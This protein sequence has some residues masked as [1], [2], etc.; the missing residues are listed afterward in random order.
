MRV[1]AKETRSRRY[2]LWTINENGEAMYQGS[3]PKAVADLKIKHWLK[4]TKKQRC[5]K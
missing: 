2:Q 3:Y 4:E 5:T 1:E